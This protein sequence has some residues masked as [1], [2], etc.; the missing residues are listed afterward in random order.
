[1]RLSQAS[2]YG[3]VQVAVE[4]G[5]TTPGPRHLAEIIE[6][7]KADSTRVLFVQPQFSQNTA[8]M[9][10]DAIGASVIPLDPLAEDYLANM[11]TIA[12]G[13]K[14]ALGGGRAASPSPEANENR[15]NQHGY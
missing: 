9:I 10:A 14:D 7:A 15:V 13:I 5:G 1:M 11:I 4:A 12:R 6:Q 8:N 2:E 3:L